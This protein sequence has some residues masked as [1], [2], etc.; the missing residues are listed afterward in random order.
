LLGLRDLNLGSNGRILPPVAPATPPAPPPNGPR[1]P[2]GARIMGEVRATRVN[3]VKAPAAAKSDPVKAPAAAKSNPVKAPTAGTGGPIKAVDEHAPSA[4]GHAK[5]QGA[6]LTLKGVNFVLQA[7]NNRLQAE[8]FAERWARLKPTVEGTL[9]ADPQLGA[10]IRVYY[11]RGKG[12]NESAIEPVNIFQDVRVAYG[13]TREDALRRFASQSQMTQRGHG[14]VIIDDSSWYPPRQAVDIRKVP[15][16]FRSAGLATFRPGKEKLTKVKFSIVSGFDDKMQSKEVLNVPAGTSPRFLYLLPPDEITY[17][18]FKYKKAGVE[19]DM[20]LA[21]DTS[22]ASTEVWYKGVPVVKL[23][24]WA[25]PSD[26]TAAM[27]WPA[28][29]ATAT[30][31]KSTTPTDDGGLLK[32]LN[33]SL[34]R[35]VKPEFMQVIEVF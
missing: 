6:A 11:S 35:W 8:R 32:S 13:L 1:S 19:W 26:A 3:P 22:Q 20:S 14:D 27:V 33:I 18:D 30:L 21:A 24:S 4:T 12:D 25:N 16:P 34:M 7:L 9:D 5:F 29:N 23:D 2:S 28:D 10:L 17:F 15:T 31:F